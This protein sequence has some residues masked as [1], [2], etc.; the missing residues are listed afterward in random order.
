MYQERQISVRNRVPGGGR[1]GA[2]GQVAAQPAIR[3]SVHESV[4]LTGPASSRRCS[5]SKDCPCRYRK[6]L[7]SLMRLKKTQIQ[8]YFLWSVVLDRRDT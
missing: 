6:L 4:L 3:G 7:F 8:E 1:H 2:G 5:R